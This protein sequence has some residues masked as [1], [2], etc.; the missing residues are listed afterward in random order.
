MTRHHAVLAALLA[1]LAGAAAATG[2][3]LPSGFEET[4]V[5]RGLTEPTAVAFAP[6]GRIFVAEKS[7]LVKVFPGFDSEGAVLV[8]LRTNVFNF[9]DRGL[10]NLILH[11][12]FPDQP[13]LY[14]LYTLDAE[15]GGTPPL[16]GTPGATSDACDDATFNGCIAAGR[17]SRFRLDGNGAP[18]GEEVMIENWCQQYPSHSVGGLAFDA[19][20]ALYVAAGEGASYN[21]VDYGQ[22]GNPCADPPG[23]QTVPT[24]RGG[25]LRSQN[26][27]L[28][29]YG[30]ATYGGKILRIDPLSGAAWP[31]NPLAGSEVPGADRIIAQGFRQPFRMAIRPG[32]QELWIGE[33]GWQE[34]EEINRL[35][36]G[37]SSVLNF[38]W[39]CFEGELPQPGWAAAGLDVCAALYDAPASVT[40]PVFAYQHY[41]EVVEGDGCD[42]D[43]A[44]V[45]GLAFYSGG[46]YPPD[47][48]GALFFADFASRCI[49][50]MPAGDDG[51]PDPARRQRFAGQAQYPVDLVIG[52]GGDLYY[53]DIAGGTLR[54][55]RYT[56]GNEAPRAVLRADVTS[57][58]APLT[59]RFDALQSS[60]GD[61]DQL[62][63]AWDL[64][65]DG[66]LDDG[67]AVTARFTYQQPGRVM[68]RLRVSDPQ[69][70]ND[71]A[72]ATIEVGNPT[73]PQASIDAPPEGLLWHVGQEITLQGSGSDAEDGAI[74]GAQMAWRILLHH[75]P[76]GSCHTHPLQT[77]EGVADA[78]FLA[79]DHGPDSYLEVQLTVTDSTGLQTTATRSL[80][81][82]HVD[83]RFESNPPGLT[84]GLNDGV[85]TT[86]FTRPAIAGSTNSISAP[87][88]Q[89]VG[90]DVFEFVHW[91]DG[92][93]ASHTFNAPTQAAVWIATYRPAGNACVTPTPLPGGSCIG[94]CN[95]DHEVA[96][97][98]IVLGVSVALGLAT[99]DACPD[100]DPDNPGSI[101]IEGL[102]AA[103]AA[104]L[105]GCGSAP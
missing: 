59:V 6:D 95:G 102:I 65:G 29:G 34:W 82:L 100:F 17:L 73:P 28:G 43:Q 92:G 103:V 13:Y 7:G 76:G 8:D 56:A 33:V 79:P 105:D 93:G 45:T 1:T 42:T 35:P 32:A 69:G 26:L 63:Y 23:E 24:A 48:D 74:P 68:V 58:S 54:R 98:E 47:Y 25:S 9:L 3:M 12:D 5:L 70:S 80:Q 61:G 20:G 72:T 27:E 89:L 101:R 75:C 36:L 53:V 60:D 50:V 38:G 86:P 31:G 85:A 37:G 46:R 39:P 40:P 16:W 11:P 83:L 21:F 44:A 78:S 15:I 77:F 55:I 97:D 71:E 30:R 87:A 94:D 90:C 52:P 84:L 22:R 18:G 99:P 62:A 10:H 64:D 49:W 96:I 104:A 91:S 57:G 19:A 14:V 51:A 66:A 67:D 41:Q 2:T 88:Q 4:T 81:P